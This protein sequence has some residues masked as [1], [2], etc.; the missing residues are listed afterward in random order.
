VSA[1]EAKLGAKAM[2]RSALGNND[3]YELRETQKSYNSVFTPEKCSLRL[4][5]DHFWQ[6]S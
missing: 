6:I 1:I 2:G 5:N 4:E 3:G